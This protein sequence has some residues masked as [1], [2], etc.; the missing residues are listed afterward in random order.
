MTRKKEVRKTPQQLE[1]EELEQRFQ[2]GQSF[3]RLCTTADWNETVDKLLC[4]MQE[5][6]DQ[7]LSSSSILSYPP[8]A[9]RDTV[10]ICHGKQAFI[11][12][13]KEQMKVWIED[14]QV[15]E[16]QQSVILENNNNTSI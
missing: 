5:E 2:A 8:D 12:K 6:I 13:F 4:E 10:L 16:K 7:A 15:N 11:N 1:E 9:V 14:G 3:L